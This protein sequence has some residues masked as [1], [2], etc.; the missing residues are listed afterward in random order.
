[1]IGRFFE[2]FAVTVTVGVLASAVVSLTLTPMLSSRFL[3]V[4][5]KDQQRGRI[6]HTF[7]RFFTGMDNGYRRA[8][9]W[10]LDHRWGVL[11]LSLLVV[12]SSGFFLFDIDKEFVPEED[13]GRFV[14]SF[15]APLGTGID[16]TANYL[17]RIEQVLGSHEEIRTY[18][19]A[20][21]LGQ[22]GEVNRGIA[23]VRMVDR[24][25]RDVTQQVFLDTIRAELA[26]TPGVTAFASPPSIVGGQ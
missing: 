12:L 2:S 21:G 17:D 13:E 1:I 25:Q 24:D 26:E 20:V 16:M 8:L 7:D 5:Q 4:R 18:F 6:Y 10:T 11:L 15:R 3:R 22:A 23:F 9:D 14:V 19:T